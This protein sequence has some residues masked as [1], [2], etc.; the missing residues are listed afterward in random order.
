MP[1]FR[2]LQQDHGFGLSKIQY[3]VKW[4]F[5]DGLPDNRGYTSFCNT[6]P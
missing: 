2:A 3:N 4:T 1:V 5:R 6:C